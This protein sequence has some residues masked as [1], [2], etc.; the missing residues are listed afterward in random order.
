METLCQSSKLAQNPAGLLAMSLYAWQQKG[1]SQVVVMPY[2]DRLRLVSD[3]F[4]QLWGESLGK[5]CTIDGQKKYVGSTPIKAVGVTDQ[6]SQLQLYLEGPKD[7]VVL[8]IDVD[9]FNSDGHLSTIKTK[10]DRIDFLS[11]SSLAKL[12]KAEKLATEESLR[13]NDRPNLSIKMSMVNEFQLGQL[14]QLFMNVIP[15]MGSLM[16]INPFDQPA[17]E[18]IK[19]FTYGLMGRKKFDDYASKISDNPHDK[20][21]IF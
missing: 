7:K 6:H 3:W 11:G 20:R 17:V 4:A 21:F 13:E 10:D 19:Q 8:F 12:L 16:G 5:A 14:Y 9:D 2:A 18:R 1:R 15:Y